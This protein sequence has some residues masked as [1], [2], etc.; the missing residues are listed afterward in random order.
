MTSDSVA[1]ATYLRIN[2]THTVNDPT[3]YNGVFWNP[4]DQGT[5]HTCVV[6][7]NGDAVSV[8]STINLRYEESSRS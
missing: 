6:A 4:D 7:P 2:D 1:Y 3:F 8:T 5:S